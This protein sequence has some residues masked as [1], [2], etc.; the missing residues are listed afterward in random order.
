[1]K[2]GIVLLFVILSIH[3]SSSQA[4][5]CTDSDRNASCDDPEDKC[6]IIDGL[7]NCDAVRDHLVCATFMDGSQ[8]NYFDGCNACLN[9]NVVSHSNGEC[10]DPLE[11]HICSSEERKADCGTRDGPCWKNKD[12]SKD[13]NDGPSHPVCASLSDGSHATFSNGCFA[14]AYQETNSFSNRACDKPSDQP[15]YCK[16]EDRELPSCTPL[17]GGCWFVEEGVKKC[18]NGPRYPVCATYE[19]GSEETFWDGCYACLKDDVVSYTE[20]ECEDCT[21]GDRADCATQ[22]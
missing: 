16:R 8:G 5:T 4:Y 21:E 13:C 11:A 9:E 12:G 3:Y 10:E 2:A 22:Y 6:P 20:G 19:D 7:K 1:M 14:C 17:T 15:Y 18:D